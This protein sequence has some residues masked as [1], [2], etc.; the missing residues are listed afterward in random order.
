[1]KIIIFLSFPLSQPILA[2]W[3]LIT[4]ELYQHCCPLSS[5]V[6]VLAASLCLSGGRPPSLGHCP[7]RWILD[8][9]L[10]CNMNIVIRIISEERERCE[11][12]KEQFIWFL[13]SFKVLCK[14]FIAKISSILSSNMNNMQHVVLL[15]VPGNVTNYATWCFFSFFFFL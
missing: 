4:E 6:P 12:C 14:L 1:M 11:F 3:N 2:L 7:K 9:I 13:C 10:L 8:N 15:P 5:R